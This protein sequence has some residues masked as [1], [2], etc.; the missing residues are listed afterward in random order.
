MRWLPC[1]LGRLEQQAVLLSEGTSAEPNL[2]IQGHAGDSFFSHQLLS[3][4]LLPF[5]FPANHAFL[6]LFFF[7]SLKKS[8]K[9]TRNQGKGIRIHAQERLPGPEREEAGTP[10]CLGDI[11]REGPFLL[12]VSG[13]PTS[14]CKAFLADLGTG[15]VGKL[16]EACLLGTQR[17]GSQTLVRKNA[18]EV[19]RIANG[20]LAFR[21]AILS[22]LSSIDRGKGTLQACQPLCLL[23][24][25]P[26]LVDDKV[27]TWLLAFPLSRS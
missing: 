15:E 13:Y 18:C 7:K 27:S 6:L 17:S 12:T 5:P 26:R 21:S 22:L 8:P 24:Q 2:Q 25:N 16:L 19:F 11:F 23:Y 10:S 1:S 9:E 3:G 4:F 14:P 20:H